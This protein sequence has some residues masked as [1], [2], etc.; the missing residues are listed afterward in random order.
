MNQLPEI[1]PIRYAIIAETGDDEE[2]DDRPLIPDPKVEM[3]FRQ[4]VLQLQK[5]PNIGVKSLL[6]AFFF[7]LLI[8]LPI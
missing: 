8:V 5:E 3:I 7:L 6:L 2:Y 4:Y 1:F